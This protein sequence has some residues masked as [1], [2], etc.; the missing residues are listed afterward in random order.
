MRTDV[1]WRNIPPGLGER[2]N[3][4]PPIYSQTDGATAKRIRA[5]R[6]HRKMQS[7][8]RR[9]TLAFSG[10]GAKG[11]AAPYPAMSQNRHARQ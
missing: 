3:A 1:S 10:E 6:Q 5:I 7:V 4:P 2:S 9:E 11:R 8:R